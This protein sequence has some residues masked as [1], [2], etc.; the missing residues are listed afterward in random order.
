MTAFDLAVLI[1]L[2]ELRSCCIV[3]L[4]GIVLVVLMLVTELELMVLLLYTAVLAFGAPTVRCA[5]F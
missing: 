3:I 2:I 4:T 5:S 1:L